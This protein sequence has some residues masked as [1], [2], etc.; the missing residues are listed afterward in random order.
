VNISL[1]LLALV[2]RAA[3]DIGARVQYG[4]E[5]GVRG[6]SQVDELAAFVLHGD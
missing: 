4:V 3:W 1:L 6:D 5:S 2:L